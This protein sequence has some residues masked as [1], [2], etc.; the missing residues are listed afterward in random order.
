MV[1]MGEAGAGGRGAGEEEEEE[2]EEAQE[3]KDDDNN[4]KHGGRAS[5]L[6]AFFS[7]CWGRRA[8]CVE[9]AEQVQA[10]KTEEGGL[11]SMKDG[12]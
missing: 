5:S 9:R 1:G 7:F 12:C 11:R 2:E 10:G 8:A 6:E 4:N 3:H